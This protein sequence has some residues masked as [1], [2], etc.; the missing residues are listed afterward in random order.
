MNMIRLLMGIIFLIAG[1]MRLLNYDKMVEES[2]YFFNGNVTM[3][4]LMIVLEFLLAFGLIFT[5]SLIPVYITIIF[6]FVAN[7]IIIIKYPQIIKDFK[8]VCI[9]KPTIVHL[10]LHMTY[11]II[12]I[13]LVS[14]YGKWTILN[15][16]SHQK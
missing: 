2:G 12:M 4:Y 13:C 10:V 1:I 8:E 5:N 11:L 3:S 6:L 7:V 16:I 15:N 14:G 9:Y